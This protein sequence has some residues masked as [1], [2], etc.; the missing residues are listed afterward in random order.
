MTT[1]INNLRRPLFMK[2]DAEK[3]DR[4]ITESLYARIEKVETSIFQ[5]LADAFET[6]MEAILGIRD[7][8]VSK[9]LA[10]FDTG[11]KEIAVIP[12]KLDQR[13][14]RLGPYDVNRGLK[15]I[16]QSDE[17]FGYIAL[18]MGLQTYPEN[19]AIEI[20]A[21][22]QSGK[23]FISIP[24]LIKNNGSHIVQI[25]IDVE[26]KRIEYYD[27][28]LSNPD[29][30]IIDGLGITPQQLMNSIDNLCFFPQATN[31]VNK[32]KLQTNFHD[33]GVIYLDVIVKRLSGL[34]FDDFQFM[35]NLGKLDKIR[36]H[37]STFIKETLGEEKVQVSDTGEPSVT[38]VDNFDEIL[39]AELF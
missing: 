22:I 18:P 36:A 20:Q 1:N 29:G 33:C 39:E 26:K 10:L 35:A 32:K 15:S 16:A 11:P 3:G 28:R 2:A 38:M 12:S 13:G 21:L 17:R 19:I 25:F 34:S 27:M 24:L 14:Q 9:I 7:K 31:L 8:I 6:A 23:K 5:D 37:I 4:K 30:E